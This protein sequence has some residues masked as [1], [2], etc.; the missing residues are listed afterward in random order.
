MEAGDIARS[1]GEINIAKLRSALDLCLEELPNLLELGNCS[2]MIGVDYDFPYHRP[3]VISMATVASSQMPETL[4]L[5]FYWN[6]YIY[7]MCLPLTCNRQYP[8]VSGI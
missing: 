7:H 6:F 3:S 8:S 5:Y 1:T 4:G 2:D